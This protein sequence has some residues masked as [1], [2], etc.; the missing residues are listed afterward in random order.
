MD[1]IAEIPLKGPRLKFNSGSFGLIIFVSKKI[2]PEVWVETE[3]KFIDSPISNT[4]SASN[5][6]L[7]SNTVSGPSQARLSVPLF[8][9][10]FRVDKKFI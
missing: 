1:S 9:Q 7:A 3:P 2:S 8:A 5:T 10:Q 6:V 4:V